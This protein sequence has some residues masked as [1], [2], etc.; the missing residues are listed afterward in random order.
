[1]SI[2]TLLLKLDYQL[3]LA[4]MAPWPPNNGYLM[5]LIGAVIV[6]IGFIY[7]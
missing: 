3:T 6:G 2:K 4:A 5:T 7:L 1:V